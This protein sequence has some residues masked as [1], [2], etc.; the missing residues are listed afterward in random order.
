MMLW[1]RARTKTDEVTDTVRRVGRIFGYDGLNIEVTEGKGWATRRDP[2]GLTLMVD[3]TMLMPQEIKSVHGA[4]LPDYVVPEKYTMY[5][6]AHELGHIED[7]IHPSS[8]IDSLQQNDSDRFFW[9]VVDDGVINSRLRDIPLLDSLTNQIYEDMLFPDTN[10]TELPK[11]IQLMYGYLTRA[12]TPERD[13]SVD[14]DVKASL[15]GLETVIAPDGSALNFYDALADIDTS[16]PQ[17]REL[18]KEVL[19]PL[20]EQF[21]T[22]DADQESSNQSIA[23][24]NANRGGASIPKSWQEAYEKYTEGTGAC[25]GHDHPDE[26][27]TL[28]GENSSNAAQAGAQTDRKS[29]N[30]AIQAA[31]QAAV[32]AQVAENAEDTTKAENATES[33][34]KIAGAIAAELHLA[35]PEALRYASAIQSLRP[36]IL[37]LAETFQLLAVPSVEYTSPRYRRDPATN[38]GSLSHRDIYRAVIA[39]YSA[40]D[41]VIWRPVETIAKKEGLNFSGLDISLVVDVSGSMAGEPAEVSAQCFVMLAESV[42]A[43]RRTMATKHP[44]APAPD[45]RI[46]TIVFGSESKVVAPIGHTINPKAKGAAFRTIEQASS[47]STI[48]SGALQ[49][50]ATQAKAQPERSQVVYLI[51]DGEFWDYDTAHNMARQFGPNTHLLQLVIKYPAARPLTHQ[52]AHISDP[53]QLPAVIYQHVHQITAQYI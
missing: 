15:D 48:V 6:T 40:Q 39:S 17:R 26:N 43:A 14:A 47:G 12:V 44:A 29:M 13:Y 30:E 32:A 27:N 51:T 41:P 38:G 42:E 25:V 16:L 21:R 2:N 22:D 10:F 1:E 18:T 28:G 36:E 53:H 34:D 50:I 24:A 7:F 5:G 4:T 49:K 3:P 31:A 46:Q 33:L 35:K 20:Y 11:H 52:I 8:T 9:N 23:S 19:K 45:V 37:Q